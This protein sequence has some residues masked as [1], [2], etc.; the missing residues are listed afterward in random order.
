MYVFPQPCPFAQHYVHVYSVLTVD[1]PVYFPFRFSLS[2]AARAHVTSS[3]QPPDDILRV[4]LYIQ[5][6]FS[7][8]FNPLHTCSTALAHSTSVVPRPSDVHYTCCDLAI[9]GS[10]NSPVVWWGG[11]RVAIFKYSKYYGSRSRYDTSCPQSDLKMP[12]ITTLLQ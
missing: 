9:F 2:I 7:G 4:D 1:F 5:Y 12:Q 11:G 6:V 3:P 8:L 10:L